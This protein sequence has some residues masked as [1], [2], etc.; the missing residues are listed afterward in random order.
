VAI[1][2]GHN[3][4]VDAADIVLVRSDLRDLAA[5]FA[6]ARKT[7]NTIWLNFLWALLFNTCALPVAAGAFW[8]YG[9]LMTPQVAVCLMLGSS[10]LVVANS[11]T[12]RSFAPDTALKM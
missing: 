7:L 11:L 8:R 5:F 1:G 2:V 4:T 12:L 6:L 10:L 9:L 3:V